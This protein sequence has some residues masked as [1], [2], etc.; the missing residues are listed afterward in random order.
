MKHLDLVILAGG[1]GSRIKN[2]S[3]KKPKPL[4]KFGKLS[5]LKNLVNYLSKYNFHKIYIIAGYKG[6]LIKEAFHNKVSNLT[7]IE[8]LLEK[9]LKGTGGALNELKKNQM[10]NFILSNGDSFCPIN[11][12][13]FIKNV[14][15]KLIKVSLVK[16]KNYKSNNLLNNLNIKKGKIV[17]DRKSKFMNSGIYYV[18]KNNL[19]KFP[20]KKFS[21]END[22]LNNLIIKNKVDGEKYNDELIDIGTPQNLRIAKQKLPQIF[23][24]PA[25]FLDRDGVINHDYGYVH[26]MNDFKLKKNVIK[27]L[28]YLNKLN[29]YIFIVT[30]QSGIARGY[31]TEKKFISFQKNIN[32]SLSKKNIYFH[33]TLYCPHHIEGKIKKYRI[34][35]NCRKPKTL[36]LKNINKNFDIDLNK[37][38]FM[39]DKKT[40]HECAK[41]YKIKFYLVKRDFYQ[42]LNDILNQI[43][44]FAR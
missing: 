10:K 35:C 34:N 14:G 41:R 30:N 20:V 23:K 42:D 21:F 31:Y 38:F 37:S 39:G 27:G 18:N 19:K 13:H 3:K 12:N 1:L 28:K 36:M 17:F 44:D 8:C 26:K 25:I 29:Y 6:D 7:K 40:D 15:N 32:E 33:D 9:K 11:L 5:F 24:K 22:Y 43:N 2:I 16:N 4:I